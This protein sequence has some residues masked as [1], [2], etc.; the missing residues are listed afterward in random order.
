MSSL[1]ADRSDP[2]LEVTLLTTVH[3]DGTQSSTETPL[4]KL[5]AVRTLLAEKVTPTYS[6]FYDSAS[7]KSEG[8]YILGFWPSLK[9]HEDF[10]NDEKLSNEILSPQRDILSWI[11]TGHVGLSGTVEEVRGKMAAAKAVEIGQ[12]NIEI[13]MKT[14][15]LEVLRR[16]D[17]EGKDEYQGLLIAE[18]W[19]VEGREKRNDGMVEYVRI[20]G[21]ENAEF[22]GKALDR[23][24][25]W[26]EGGWLAEE[27]QKVCERIRVGIYVNME[28]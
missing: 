12:W 18:G 28:G 3:Q 15:F 20:K 4:T 22:A 17:K 23:H 1:A 7:R 5:R 2:V 8:I 21:W 24:E 10:L 26:A 25:G 13:S 9:D 19:N 27:E 14:D 6:Q 11:W 16:Q